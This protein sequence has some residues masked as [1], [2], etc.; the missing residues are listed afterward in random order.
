MSPLPF[1]RVSSTKMGHLTSGPLAVPFFD[2]ARL[3]ALVM[4]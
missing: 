1:R 2:E 4:G 3:G